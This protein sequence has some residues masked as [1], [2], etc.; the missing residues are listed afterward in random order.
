VKPDSIDQIIDGF[1]QLW[2][3]ADAVIQAIEPEIDVRRAHR[4]IVWQRGAVKV[5]TNPANDDIAV[6]F[7]FRYHTGLARRAV[8][9]GGW[10]QRRHC[11]IRSADSKGIGTIRHSDCNSLHCQPM[12][13]N[14]LMG[15]SLR[16]AGVWRHRSLLVTGVVEG[17]CEDE[18]QVARLNGI[19]SIV[20]V[21]STQI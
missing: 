11:P 9:K 1:H 13:S 8:C 14:K 20:L 19:R 21:A 15:S 7:N 18:G 5:T 3:V 6:H 16:K 12:I 4:L 17:R 2:N 10:L